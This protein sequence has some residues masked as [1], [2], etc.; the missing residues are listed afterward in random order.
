MFNKL[1]NKK[2]DYKFQEPENTSCFVCSHILDRERPILY[3]SH[4][5]DDSSW[6]FLCGHNDHTEDNIRIIGLGQATEIDNSVN[7]LYEMP[8]GICAERDNVGDK[9][10]PYKMEE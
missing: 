9:W 8:K 3:V 7:D 6:Q 10:T 2:S 5:K 1:F 4:D